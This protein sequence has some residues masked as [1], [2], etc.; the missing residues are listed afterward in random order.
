MSLSALK[1]LMQIKDAR[2]Q[3]AATAHSDALDAETKA[4]TAWKDAQTKLEKHKDGL[5]DSALVVTD[6]NLPHQTLKYAH[7]SYQERNLKRVVKHASTQNAQAAEAATSALTT[8]RN[9]SRKLETTRELFKKLSGYAGGKAEQQTE[10]DT[11]DF[12]KPSTFRFYTT[13]Q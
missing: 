13:G 6:R 7:H 9:A 5:K 12:S 11:E 10:F 3:R 4:R 1:Q 8:H 2:A